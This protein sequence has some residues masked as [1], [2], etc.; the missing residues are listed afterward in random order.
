MTNKTHVLVASLIVS[1]AL[2][3]GGVTLLGQLPI[4]VQGQRGGQA[5]QGAG[6]GQR[7]QQGQQA[8]QGG[9]GQRGAQAAAPA[10][11]QVVSPIA[12]ASA[13]IT[14]PGRFYETLMELKPTDNLAHF[15]YVTREYFVSGTANNQPYKTRIVIRR[16]ADNSRFSGLILAESMHPSGNPWMFHFTHVYSMSSGHIGLEVLT[17]A[18]QGFT[19]F[20]PERYKDLQIGNGQA[21]EILAQVGALLKSKQADNP[22]AGLPVRKIIL[23]GSSASAGVAVNY[24]PAHM[25][26]RL[27]DM[28]PIYDGFLPTSNNSAIPSLD[29]PTIQVP[30]MLEVFRGNGTTRL[31]SDMPGSQIRVYEFAGMAHIDSRDAAAY[32]PDPCKNPI[33]RFPLAVYMS[34]ALDHLF[35]WVDKGTLPPRGDRYYVDFNT[36]NDGSLLALDEFGNVKGGIRNP[37]VDVPVKSYRVPNTGSE[38]PIKNPHPF[39]AARG[40]AAQNQL[41]GLSNYEES[42]TSAQIK[43][44]YKNKKEYQTKVQQ[45]YDELVKQ[46]WALPLPMLRDV[47]IG[48]AAK[49]AF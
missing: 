17:S 31:D 46:R 11:P 12:A 5:G 13:E 3:G 47:V 10:A 16:P 8:G 14:G 4:P 1:V 48:D 36:E 23:A 20:N 22:L 34:V 21:S 19:E 38:P 44:L 27:A 37:Y 43:K 9:R 33:S 49:V 15:N 24:M 2:A 25:Q 29:V 40:E 32:Y 6:Q 39:I 28:R 18:T 42:L 7:G 35:A 45:R 41:C 30:T 26:Y